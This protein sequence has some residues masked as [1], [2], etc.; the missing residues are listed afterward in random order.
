[1]IIKIS[2]T[3]LENKFNNLNKKEIIILEYLK[4]IELQLILIDKTILSLG[5]VI[6]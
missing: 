5:P 3:N 2:L 1:M 6:Y 4:I